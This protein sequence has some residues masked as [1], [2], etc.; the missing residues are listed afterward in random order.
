MHGHRFSG[1]RLLA[2]TQ[3]YHA[4]VSLRAAAVLVFATSGS[5]VGT[6]VVRLVVQLAAGL[7]VE[8]CGSVPAVY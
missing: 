1:A 5:W 6:T 7:V 2:F 3:G 4:D 8:T